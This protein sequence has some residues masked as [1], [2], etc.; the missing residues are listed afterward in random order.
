[1]FLVPRNHQAFSKHL[2]GPEG[3]HCVTVASSRGCEGINSFLSLALLTL[4]I[5]DS[6]VKLVSRMTGGKEKYCS[7]YSLTHI[8]PYPAQVSLL[9]GRAR[10]QGYKERGRGKVSMSWRRRR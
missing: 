5:W 6:A 4:L 8:Q 10:E 3:P 7:T 9:C 2:E 1:M